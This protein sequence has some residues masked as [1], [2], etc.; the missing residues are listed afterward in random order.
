MAETAIPSSTQIQSTTTLFPHVSLPQNIGLVGVIVFGVQCVSLATA[1]LLPFSTVAGIYPGAN[2][3]GILAVALVFCLLHAYCYALIGVAAPFSGADYV[4]S[5]RVLA[6]PLGFVSSWTLVLLTGMVAGSM[7]ALIPQSILPSLFSTASIVLQNQ[8]LASMAIFIKTPQG[9]LAIGTTITVIA[10]ILTVIPQKTMLRILSIGLVFGLAAWAVIY[11]QLA[12][13]DASSFITAWDRFMGSGSFS[14]QVQ[15][16]TSQGMTLDTS[17][18]IIISAGGLMGFW[19]FSG[20]YIATLFAG[21]VKKPEVNLVRGSLLSLVIT[22]AVLIGAV[23][24]M[25]RLAPPQWISA[26]SYLF[27]LNQHTG[28]GPWIIF[29]AAI[30]NPNL[31]LVM[32]V[33]LAWLW[34]MINLVQTF[35][36]GC[37]RIILA[38]AEDGL[39]P[40]IFRYV[41]PGMKTPMFAVLLVA[42][43]VQIG[44]AFSASSGALTG[45]MNFVFF[46]VIS[47]VI[48]VVSLTLLPFKNKELFARAPQMIRRKLGP[49]PLISLVGGL[50][51]SYFGHILVTAF[52]IP[53]MSEPVTLDSIIL[54]SA[55]IV[56]GF[57]WFWIFWVRSRRYGKDPA[58]KFKSLPE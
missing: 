47:Q 24:L 57:I 54:L 12:K 46:A 11:Y 44:T 42:I 14:K 18:D 36:Y 56:S 27:Q 17:L 50:T 55:V 1:G 34:M 6:P 48:P 20:Y 9:I 40:Q 39:A 22:G 4:L 7:V 35:M 3:A 43:L 38:W 49:L 8:T 53:K 13:A 41:H 16:A 32:F 31:F 15:M 19:I 30:L 51:L 25:N 58:E 21:E 10:F 37:S 5:T 29:Y 23:L 33:A 28:A 52:T 2:L 26:Q 45:Q